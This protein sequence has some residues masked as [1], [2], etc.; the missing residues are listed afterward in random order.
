MVSR[1]K[2]QLGDITAMDTEAVVNS[3]DETLA[4]GGPVHVAI[5]RAAGPGL[6]AECQGVGD[7]PPGE[8]RLTGGHNLASPYVIHTVAP[9]WQDGGGAETEILASCYVSAL[10]LAK[11]HGIRSVAFPSIGSGIQPQIPLEVA[12]PVAVKAILGFLD[13]NELPAQ[14]FMVCFNAQ[15][16]QAHQKALKEALP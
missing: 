2:L 16:Y 4:A 7:C 9:T 10:T 1:L 11:A 13:A 8:A 3:T 6:E 5:H 12:A 14:V 15:T